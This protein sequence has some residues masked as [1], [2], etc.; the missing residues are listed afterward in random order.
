MGA[1][2]NVS[3]LDNYRKATDEKRIKIVLD[4]YSSFMPYVNAY[5]AGLIRTI[6]AE[7]EYNRRVALGDPGVRVQTSN[8]GNPTSSE[9][10]E[11][12]IV[13]Q[14]VRA[15][16]Y[17]TALRGADKFETHKWEILLLKDMREIYG[18]V[19]E[20]IGS[21]GDEKDVFKRYL[22]REFKLAAIAGTEGVT[23]EAMKKRF[24]ILRK[25]VVDNSLKWLKEQRPYSY[26]EQ[27]G[28]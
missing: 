11:D 4:H 14:A 16:D 12:M 8:I 5:E 21:L 1:R 10:D 20:Q 26:L 22:K 15:G 6:K 3:I 18:L 9:G 28:A 19:E 7:R 25:D 13:R 24:G 27:K 2:M 23:S 17:I